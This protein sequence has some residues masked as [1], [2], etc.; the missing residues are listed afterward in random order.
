MAKR[1]TTLSLDEKLVKLFKTNTMGVNLSAWVNAR[2]QD[3]VN[4]NN[5]NK[6]VASSKDV[7]GK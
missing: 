6:N 4:E 5:L 2:L 3:F 7:N 1:S